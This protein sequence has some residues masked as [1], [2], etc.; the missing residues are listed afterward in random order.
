MRTLHLLIDFQTPFSSEN[1]FSV[2]QV[3]D[4]H[5]KH[6]FGSSFLS[7][8]MSSGQIIQEHKITY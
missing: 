2:H 8:F 1:Y 7:G 3:L 6:S 5:M 4:L